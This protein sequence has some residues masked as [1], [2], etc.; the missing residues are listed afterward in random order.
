MSRNPPTRLPLRARAKVLKWLHS[1]GYGFLANPNPDDDRNIF[2][3]NSIVP[4]RIGEGERLKDN[5]YVEVSYVEQPDGRLRATA[6][7][8]LE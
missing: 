6:I 1:A 4:L 8:F 7:E 3:H 5:E 2:V